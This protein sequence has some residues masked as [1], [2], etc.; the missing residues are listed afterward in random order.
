MRTSPYRAQKERGP[1]FP[2][3]SSPHPQACRNANCLPEN[4]P[5][6][7]PSRSFHHSPSHRIGK[8]PVDG[9]IRVPNC[10]T[11]HYLRP[12]AASCP[13][14]SHDAVASL[15]GCAGCSGNH[16]AGCNPRRSPVKL[17]RQWARPT[18]ALPA[19]PIA[20]GCVQPGA[21]AHFQL[22]DCRAPAAILRSAVPGES[23]MPCAGFWMWR[24]CSRLSWRARP[25]PGSAAACS[26]ASRAETIPTA[27]IQRW[28]YVATWRPGTTHP[29][30]TTAVVRTE[31]TGA[32]ASP[33][34][35]SALLTFG[36]FGRRKAAMILGL[37]LCQRSPSA[38][39]SSLLLRLRVLRHRMKPVAGDEEPQSLSG[40]EF[41]GRKTRCQTPG[42]GSEAD[43]R[44]PSHQR[45]ARD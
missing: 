30:V 31:P 37:S 27:Q 23:L 7:K 36:G 22:P 5:V 26:V 44:T 35:K 19:Q 8:V 10:D 39:L 2:C 32:N 40:A 33:R 24:S 4:S 34:Q 3:D 20:S 29:G 42:F 13:S 11:R 17:Q 41:R 45:P 16:P 1:K 43:V 14:A 6:L 25:S 12:G 18:G 38:F 15:P 21:S 9:T 28:R